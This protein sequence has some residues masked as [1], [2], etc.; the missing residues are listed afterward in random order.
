MAKAQK[1]ERALFCFWGAVKEKTAVKV[2]ESHQ[3]GKKRMALKE[4]FGNPQE[5]LN[6]MAEYMKDGD[7]AS[8]TDLI[9]SYISNSHKYNN[10][11]EFAEAIGT[12]RQ[13]LHRM[14]AHNDAVAIKY[15]FGAIEQ[16][17]QDANE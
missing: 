7:V 5:V 9:S 16:I 15:F 1:T 12:T 11:D 10:Q 13:T 6:M 3:A 14:L 17:Y 2:K 4:R 8:I